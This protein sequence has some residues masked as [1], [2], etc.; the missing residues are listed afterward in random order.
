MDFNPKVYKQYL[1]DER[2]VNEHQQF[3]LKKLHDST[4]N[5]RY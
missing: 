4:Y 1:L 5:L 2:I 3:Y